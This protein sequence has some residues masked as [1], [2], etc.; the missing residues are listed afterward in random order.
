MNAYL[1]FNFSVNAKILLAVQ[2]A[3]TLFS[4]AFLMLAPTQSRPAMYIPITS[5]APGEIAGLA[6]AGDHKLLGS[7]PIPG[8]LVV[9][10]EPQNPV[11]A[12]FT[13]GVL[14]VAVSYS[15]CASGRS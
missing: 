5:S 7:G 1:R 12:L 8:S 15:S 2:G 13:R 11:W 4:L 3:T 9:R 10:G 6:T 14:I